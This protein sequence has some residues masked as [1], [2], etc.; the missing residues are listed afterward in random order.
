MRQNEK[1]KFTNLK[2]VNLKTKMNVFCMR[3]L[4]LK[5]MNDWKNSKQKRRK[6]LNAKFNSDVK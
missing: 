3:Q 1:D 5:L 2:G 4:I 6:D